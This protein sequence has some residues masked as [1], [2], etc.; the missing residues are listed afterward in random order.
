MIDRLRLT[1]YATALTL[2]IGW[3]LYVGKG[4]VVP[5]VFSILVVYVIDGLTRLLFRLPLLER[6]VPLRI[7]YAVASLV[8]AVALAA[9]ASLV[10]ANLGSVAALAPQYSA[11]LLNTIQGVAES[12]GI[13]LVPTW[14][15][16]R[17]ELLARVNAQQ[18]VG[19]TVSSVFS[20]ASSL[21]V[22]LLYVAFLLIERR[23]L[24]AKIAR[25]S[26]DPQQVARIQKVIGHVNARIGAYLALK[27]LVSA[28]QGVATWAILAFLGVEFAVFWAA[29]AG[30]LNY[31]PYIGSVLGV[32]FPVAFA[33]M[34]FADPG[35]VIALLLSLAAA[36]FFIGFFLDP[37]LMGNS[38]N[39]SPF[40][41]LVSLAVW[42]AL[43]GVPG[44]FL[45]VPI[46]ACL[47]LVFAEFEGTRPVA[48]LLSRNG[49]V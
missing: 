41:I 18:I 14:A 39:L 42:S 21:V 27:T 24:S 26:G 49:E 10:A 11:S 25:M 16:L 23:A 17:R 29:L 36:Q 3:L 30:L 46:T 31:V 34:Q 12:M 35:A 9:I 6:L 8:I 47:A 20:I 1:V 33:T 13:D 5:I 28:I 40:A 2:A 19:S 22:V 38:L 44:A 43:W 37:Y 32:A 48:V 15:T 4:I 7:G 45:A